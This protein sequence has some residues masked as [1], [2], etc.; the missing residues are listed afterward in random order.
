MGMKRTIGVVTLGL[1]LAAGGASLVA[2]GEGQKGSDRGARRGEWLAQELG[3]TA[4][5]KASFESLREQHRSEMK[6]LMDEGRTLHERLRAALKAENPDPQ[7]VGEATLAVEQH[8]K[9]VEAS[10]KAFHE[11]LSAQLTPE[12][13][14]K[15]DALSER[16]RMGGRGWGRGHR[17]APET[18]PPSNPRS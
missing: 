12:Q 16:H 2:A 1:A 15:F 9:A 7:A 8:R 5:Q 13:K 3:L 6:P 4:E 11:K 14:A 10:Q 17:E 18:E